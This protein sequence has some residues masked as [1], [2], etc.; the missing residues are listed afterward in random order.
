MGSAPPSSGH[1]RDIS[2]L[3]LGGA[4]FV[5]ASPLRHVWATDRSPWF[6]P[7]VLWLALIVLARL[8]ARGR[9]Q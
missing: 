5:L 6:L 3:L 8:V 1:D 4:A 9:G 7:F 2:W